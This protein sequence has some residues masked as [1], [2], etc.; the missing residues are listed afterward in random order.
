MSKVFFIVVF[1]S[2][3]KWRNVIGISV[4]GGILRKH[5]QT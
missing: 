2:F 1:S 3:G 4:I 5:I